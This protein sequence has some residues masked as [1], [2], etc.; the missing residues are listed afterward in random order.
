MYVN[1]IK[2][3]QIDTFNRLKM[4]QKPIGP[5]RPVGTPRPLTSAQIGHLA[6]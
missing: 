3:K 5:N 4:I 6:L 1:K 2:T